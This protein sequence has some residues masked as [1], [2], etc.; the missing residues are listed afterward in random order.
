MWGVR[1]EVQVFMRELHTHLL[2]SAT[3]AGLIK[4]K[5]KKKKPKTQTW[6][7]QTPKH[8]EIYR[9]YIVKN[10]FKKFDVYPEILPAR[11]QL[12]VLI[13]LLFI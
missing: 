11:Q 4:K 2:F 9:F 5:K 1:A 13:I 6:K 12:L 3:G 8:S 7:T 10:L